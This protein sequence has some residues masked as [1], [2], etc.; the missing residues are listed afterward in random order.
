MMKAASRM[1]GEPEEEINESFGAEKDDERNKD[2]AGGG[3][4][5]FL[6][7]SGITSPTEQ[8]SVVSDQEDL[9][10]PPSWLGGLGTD[11]RNL[12]VSLKE[13]AGGVVGFVHRSAMSVAAEI[14]ELEVDYAAEKREGR[15]RA[16]FLRL[17]W[18]TLVRGGADGEHYVED[19]DLKRKILLLS[20]DESSFLAPY[21]AS[22][23]DEEEAEAES[24]FVLDEPRIQLIRQLLEVDENLASTH[25]RLS[26]RSRVRE[27][28]FWRNYFYHC[29]RVAL[30]HEECERAAAVV[31]DAPPLQDPR[32]LRTRSDDDSSYVCVNPDVVISPPTSLDWPGFVSSS[33]GDLVVLGSPPPPPIPYP[34][35]P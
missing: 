17:P 19:E 1:L 8:G 33:E 21:S 2:D 26:G 28:A 9:F 14:A 11:F 12:A 22:D 25:A 5:E 32:I 3:K 35:S 23:D 29:G 30:A 15:D 13:T 10:A 27:S 31:A 4:E 24:P 7:D 16:P 34:D 18:E 20:D 6:S